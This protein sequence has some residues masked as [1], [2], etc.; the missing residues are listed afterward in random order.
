M[1]SPGEL[2]LLFEFD[3][4]GNKGERNVDPPSCELVDDDDFSR[5]PGEHFFTLVVDDGKL[6]SIGKVSLDFTLCL[7]FST[8]FWFPI[9][10]LIVPPEPMIDERAAANADWKLGSNVIA[11]VAAAM[12]SGARVCWLGFM[13]IFFCK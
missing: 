12:V 11:L 10:L 8:K 1:L 2:D 6:D 9:V 4:N 13:A 5:K 3:D 7:D